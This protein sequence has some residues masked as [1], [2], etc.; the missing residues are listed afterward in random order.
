MPVCMCGHY[1]LIMCISPIVRL[2]AVIAGE[3]PSPQHTPAAA[4][5][6]CSARMCL[7]NAN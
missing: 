7:V 3:L 5:S 4:C 6:R 1:R 2:G